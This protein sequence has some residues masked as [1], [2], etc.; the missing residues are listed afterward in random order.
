MVFNLLAI[1]YK[2]SGVAKGGDM[3]LGLHLFDPGYDP[4]YDPAN[5]AEDFKAV[6]SL[7]PHELAAGRD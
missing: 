1:H 2:K 5:R 6:N 4:E 3:P 7:S